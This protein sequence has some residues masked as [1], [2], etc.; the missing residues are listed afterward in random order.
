M[1]GEVEAQDIHEVAEYR[2]NCIA[3]TWV[4]RQYYHHCTALLDD[5]LQLMST[6]KIAGNPPAPLAAAAHGLGALKACRGPCR[7]LG[8]HQ[9][10]LQLL[11]GPE[12]PAAQRVAA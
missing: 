5:L 12:A 1:K 9:E 11:E 8:R 4:G 7:P 6:Y 3:S 10:R 2:G